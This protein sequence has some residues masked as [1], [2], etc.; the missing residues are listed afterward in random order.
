M[1]MARL[2]RESPVNAV[3]EGSGN[4]QCLDMLRAMHKSPASLEAF[5]KEINLAKGADRHLD[6]AIA[7]LESEFTHLENI[8]YR[9]RSI[10]GQ[11]ALAIQAATM[12]GYA[13]TE[14][15]GAFCASRLNSANRGWLYGVLPESVNCKEIIERATPVV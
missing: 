14:M 2:F 15:A 8:E 13:D 4:V 10:V 3:W 12:F 11:M 7:R 9:A 1:V 6:K 5:F